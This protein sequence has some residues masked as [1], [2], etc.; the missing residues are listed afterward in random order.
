M[1]I[2]LWNIRAVFISLITK[3]VIVPSCAGPTAKN[4]D[5]RLYQDGMDNS[6]QIIELLA[7]VKIYVLKGIR[8]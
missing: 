2:A 6:I 1:Y 7:M 3:H 8:D 4:S 5:D